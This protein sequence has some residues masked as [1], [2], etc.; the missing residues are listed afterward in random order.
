MGVRCFLCQ[1]NTR[2]MEDT[3]AQIILQSE[4]KVFSSPLEG[5]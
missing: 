3:L 5:D 4:N 2:L 1:Q